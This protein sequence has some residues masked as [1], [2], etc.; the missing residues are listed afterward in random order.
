M[1]IV[2]IEALPSGDDREFVP[3]PSLLDRRVLPEPFL[4]L[5]CRTARNVLFWDL[6][7]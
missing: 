3:E 6:L 2:A 4:I 1:L 5:A 7:K